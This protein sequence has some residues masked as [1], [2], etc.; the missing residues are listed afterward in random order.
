MTGSRTVSDTV[1]AAAR[2]VY[3]QRL[4]AYGYGGQHGAKARHESA[5]D[6]AVD[7]VAATIRAEERERIAALADAEAARGAKTG[8]DRISLRAFAQRLREEAP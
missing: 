5:L 1:I 7:A 4:G 2:A 3:R 8:L 6:A